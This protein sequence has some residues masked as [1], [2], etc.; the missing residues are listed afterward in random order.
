MAASL[1]PS[2]ASVVCTD[3]VMLPMHFVLG[4]DV[5]VFV[6]QVG[7]ASGI[8]ILWASDTFVKR[9]PSHCW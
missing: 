6:K 3:I 2:A 8:V 9:L 5:G 4:D 7:L 1:L